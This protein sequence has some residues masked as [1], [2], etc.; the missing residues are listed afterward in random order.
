MLV[1]VTRELQKG[2]MLGDSDDEKLKIYRTGTSEPMREWNTEMVIS[3]GFCCIK[4]WKATG[5]VIADPSF[6]ALAALQAVFSW[7]STLWWINQKCRWH[8]DGSHQLDKMETIVEVITT[9]VSCGTPQCQDGRW[10][11][12][13]GHCETACDAPEEEN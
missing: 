6:P 7:R 13:A 8:E 4:M 3:S 11:K 9:E 5:W 2:G 10:D 1:Q 12:M